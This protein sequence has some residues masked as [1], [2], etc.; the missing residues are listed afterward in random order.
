MISRDDLQTSLN[1]WHSQG[2]KIVFTNGCFDILHYGHIDY[3][4]KA[5]SLGDR[6]IVGINS[7]SSVTKLK[8]PHRP[9]QDEYSRQA[10]MA[11]LSC[12]DVVIL[13]SEATPLNLIHFVKPDILVKGGD[14]DLE[15]IVGSSFVA[16]YG[17]Q[18]KTIPYIEG[19]STTNIER[20]IKNL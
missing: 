16:S 18:V 15:A 12:V 13:F 4:E 17:G 11:A 1:Q 20:K 8:G 19:Y 3:L 6:L 10:I 7:D 14:W 2:E 5:K 9:I